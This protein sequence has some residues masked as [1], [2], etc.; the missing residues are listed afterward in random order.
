MEICVIKVVLGE[1]ET[2]TSKCMLD[3]L[4]VKATS[5][6]SEVATGGVL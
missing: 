1:D 2:Y 5:Q 4:R 3:F 6:R